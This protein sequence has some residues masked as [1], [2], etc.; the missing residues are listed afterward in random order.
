MRIQRARACLERYSLRAE[1]YIWI[2]CDDC[3]VRRRND[4]RVGV[5]EIAG[6][7]IRR[8]LADKPFKAPSFYR[9]RKANFL[10]HDLRRAGDLAAAE[11]IV[12]IVHYVEPDRC[13]T[14]DA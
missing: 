14:G 12:Q 8:G 1:R 7:R 9:V 11:A 6:S 13:G 5:V 4:S 2:E 10:S 3:V